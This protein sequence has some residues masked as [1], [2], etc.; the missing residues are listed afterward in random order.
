MIV[1]EGDGSM[2][3][4]EET[5]GNANFLT[6]YIKDLKSSANAVDE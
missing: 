1:R 2:I 6:D 3:A 5:K 4:R